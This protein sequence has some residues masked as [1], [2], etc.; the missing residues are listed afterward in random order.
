MRSLLVVV[1]V[2]VFASSASAWTQD[3]RYNAAVQT[4]SRQ[5]DIVA[6]C[7]ITGEPENP[8]DYFAWGYTFA[9]AKEVYLNERVCQGL[10]ML[11]NR[12][13]SDPMTAAIGAVVLAHEAFHLALRYSTRLD[14]G[15]TECRAM[16]NFRYTVYMLSGDPLWA[17][18]LYPHA[19][20]FH[21]TLLPQY[22]YKP[23]KCYLPS[24]PYVRS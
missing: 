9:F 21:S 19:L 1:A 5:P 17:M 22:Q 23:P 2:L 10:R 24:L 14:E 12:D 4:I 7:Y 15:Y 8:D 11:V 20:I 6:R 3:P 16:Q 13:R 18:E